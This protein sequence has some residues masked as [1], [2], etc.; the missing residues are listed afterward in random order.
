MMLSGKEKAQLLLSLLGDKAK[1]VLSR[2]SPESASL[3]TESIGDIPYVTSQLKY[4]FLEDILKKAKVQKVEPVE[5]E[6][7][8]NLFETAHSEESL[9]GSMSSE[10]LSTPEPDEAELEEDAVIP[11]PVKNDLRNPQQIASILSEQKP[12]IIAFV[13]SKIDEDLKVKIENFLPNSILS[14]IQQ[15]KIEKLPLSDAVF[16]RIYD[17]IFKR[18]PEDDFVPIE[19]VSASA[20]QPVEPEAGTFSWDQPFF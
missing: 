6:A 11:E 1:N 10:T 3:L 18:S 7:S 14:Q 13:L 4:E 16:N 15:I 12:Q 20:D 2:M 8:E 5:Q 19:E 17:T 9:F